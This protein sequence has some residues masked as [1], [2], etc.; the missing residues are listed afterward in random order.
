MLA[1]YRRRTYSGRDVAS[2]AHFLGAGNGIQY[3]LVTS[4][5]H[6]GEEHILPAPGFCHPYSCIVL[7]SRE[8]W[9]RRGIADSYF[10]SRIYAAVGSCWPLTEDVESHGSGRQLFSSWKGE[11]KPEASWLEEQD[12]GTQQW[13]S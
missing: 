7:A 12:A 5:L 11:A 2:P 13:A 9:A 1:V 4:L 3:W 6:N 8:F 10:F